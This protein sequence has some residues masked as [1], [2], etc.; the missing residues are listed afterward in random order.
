MKH[1]RQRHAPVRSY[2]T[3]FERQEAAG[4]YISRQQRPDANQGIH[5]DSLIS[6]MTLQISALYLFHGRK[7]TNPI[8]YV[9]R[10]IR[11]LHPQRPHPQGMKSTVHRHPL[12][13]TTG[14]PILPFEPHTKPPRVSLERSTSSGSPLMTRLWSSSHTRPRENGSPCQA[15][16]RPKSS[17][18]WIIRCRRWCTRER[19]EVDTF[20]YRCGFIRSTGDG[21][22]RRG[23]LTDAL[24]G[25][26]ITVPIL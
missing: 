21:V 14:R 26:G 12:T 13:R 18:S 15:W 3:K 11:N 24:S 1:C 2:E 20:S 4:R 7:V 23:C 9:R 22:W 19:K 5:R 6:M 16:L 8:Q 25:P 17:P 10:C